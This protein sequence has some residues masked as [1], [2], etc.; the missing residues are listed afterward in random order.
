M[1]L[2]LL[3][4]A[5]ALMVVCVAAVEKYHGAEI[6]DNDFAEFE[7]FDDGMGCKLKY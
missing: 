2:K 1:R 4:L 5:C 6:E 7:D 3:A